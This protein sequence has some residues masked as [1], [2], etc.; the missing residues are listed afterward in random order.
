MNKV[1]P[2]IQL[3]ILFCVSLAIIGGCANKQQNPTVPVY[4]SSSNASSN[5]TTPNPQYEQV[6]D[7]H[8]RWIGDK[9]KN[10]DYQHLII[11][12]V[13]MTPMPENITADQQTR[14][15][16]LFTAFNQILLAELSSKISVVNTPGVGV[17]R[18]QPT[19]T[20]VSSSMQG[21]KIYEIVPLAAL[22]GGIKA[23][24]GTRDKEVELWLEAL[25]VDSQTDEL[26]ARIVRRGSSDQ[27]DRE[28]ATV[29]DVREMLQ[30]WA[31]DSATSAAKLFN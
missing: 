19:F 10:G 17:A 22:L 13:V 11:D 24:T 23:V 1:R 4:S 9:L 25:V 5:S 12:A 31:K 14:L 3:P 7:D 30:E 20:T 29:E 27:A 8:T 28:Q 21:M 26:L 16:E 18:I 2:I 15:H 6:S